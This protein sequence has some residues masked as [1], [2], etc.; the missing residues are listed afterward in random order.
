[1]RT[2]L[3]SAVLALAALG[4]AGCE[5]VNY[6]TGPADPRATTLH[7]VPT[8]STFHLTEAQR[9]DVRWGFDVDA[10]ERLLAHV[11]PQY[12]DNLFQAFRIPEGNEVRELWYIGDPGLQEMLEEVW[13]PAWERVPVAKIDAD[14]SGRPGKR[15]AAARR[16][17]Q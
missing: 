4:S 17:K 11:P 10:L 8:D 14:T 3:V 1:M 2:P 5:T 12:R 13:A 16:V 9:N 6:A 15:I 7:M